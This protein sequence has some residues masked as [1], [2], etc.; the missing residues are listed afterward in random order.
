MAVRNFGMTFGKGFCK[1]I[2]RRVVHAGL[3]FSLVLLAF[4][5]PL[6]DRAH[7]QGPEWVADLAYK[8]IGAFLNISTSQKW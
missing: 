4:A 1:Q 8:L 5:A 2:G 7:A 3:A 6:S